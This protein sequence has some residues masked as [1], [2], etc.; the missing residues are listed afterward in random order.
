[1]EFDM[2]RIQ[3][4]I[5]QLKELNPTQLEQQFEQI[6]MTFKEWQI[7]T[8]NILSEDGIPDYLLTKEQ[9]TAL[10][11]NKKIPYSEFSQILQQ[12]LKI[13]HVHSFKWLNNQNYGKED[14]SVSALKRNIENIIGTENIDMMDE[15]TAE[16][17]QIEMKRKPF[18]LIY[19]ILDRFLV[20]VS[21]RVMCRKLYIIDCSE[22]LD[23]LCTKLPELRRYSED[24]YGMDSLDNYDWQ[25]LNKSIES[26]CKKIETIKTSTS[27]ID[28]MR[29]L[30]MMDSIFQVLML[31]E[32]G[33]ITQKENGNIHFSGMEAKIF[34]P[35]LYQ[36][37][38]KYEC[39]TLMDYSK[40]LKNIESEH[41]EKKVSM[42]QVV[43]NALQS[44]IGE[45]AVSQVE[46]RLEEQQEEKQEENEGRNSYGE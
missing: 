39:E 45:S 22:R 36:T 17:E 19:R 37:I 4:V 31:V 46:R 32:P 40:D 14:E 1:M 38:F 44:G 11:N 21:S 23:Y 15:I 42:Y 33:E 29:N 27:E 35:I 28:L 2:N 9:V 6:K 24:L 16:A 30:D 34:E 7:F 43:E 26:I 20:V 25:E 12:Y 10:K 5:H 3:E 8:N 41:D 18:K 13:N